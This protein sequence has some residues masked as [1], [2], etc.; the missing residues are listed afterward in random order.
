MGGEVDVDVKISKFPLS[1]KTNHFL[2]VHLA[3]MVLW[4]AR[5]GNISAL[6]LHQIPFGIDVCCQV[7]LRVVFNKYVL[8]LDAVFEQRGLFGIRSNENGEHRE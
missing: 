8:L 3:H 6:T 4:N 2:K 1:V 5:C 7:Y